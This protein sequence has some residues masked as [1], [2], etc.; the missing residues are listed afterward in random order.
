VERAYGAD[1]LEDEV[2][3]AT[4]TKQIIA[5]SDPDHHVKRIKGIEKLGATAVVLMNV[6]ANDPH[7]VLRVYGERVLPALRDG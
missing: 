5:S 7:S 6:S 2:S 3:D 4:F 1:E